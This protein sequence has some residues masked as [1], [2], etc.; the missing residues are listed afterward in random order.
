MQ[1]VNETSVKHHLQE[2]ECYLEAFVA[3]LYF[4]FPR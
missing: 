4:S 3:L 2:S 1:F